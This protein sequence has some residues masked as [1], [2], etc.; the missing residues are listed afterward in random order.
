MHGL[1]LDGMNDLIVTQKTWILSSVS[2]AAE[3]YPR[4]MGD[5]CLSSKRGL[6]VNDLLPGSGKPY[7]SRFSSMWE[8][9]WE[10]L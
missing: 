8:S 10:I 7:H 4:R 2:F 9:D 1:N 6:D 5:R 3:V